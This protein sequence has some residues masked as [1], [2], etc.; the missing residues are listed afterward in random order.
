M[1]VVTQ[2]LDR[3]FKNSF[4]DFKFTIF[5]RKLFWVF[6]HKKSIFLLRATLSKALWKMWL[7]GFIWEFPYFLLSRKSWITVSRCSRWFPNFRFSFSAALK[8]AFGH[9]IPIF[10]FNICGLLQFVLSKV[11][12][13]RW[14]CGIFWTAAK[15]LLINISLV[16]FLFS[17]SIL[18]K[19]AML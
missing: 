8:K 18:W 13:L 9:S 19:F 17:L 14:N 7:I 2:Q 16:A 15:I 3:K 1:V 6:C 4:M 5:V 12:K 11:C 10:V